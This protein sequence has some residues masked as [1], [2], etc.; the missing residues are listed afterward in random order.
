LVAFLGPKRET[1]RNLDS[2]PSRLVFPEPD[3]RA[4]A[5]GVDELDA[6]S[7]KGSPYNLKRCASLLTGSSFKLVDGDDTYPGMPSKVLLF[8][9]QKAPRRPA[10]LCRDHF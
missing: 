3:A 9:I 2:S 6:G 10:L 4:A 1:L 7:L 8:P 5:I